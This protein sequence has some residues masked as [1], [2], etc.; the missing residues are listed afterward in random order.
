MHDMHENTI[1]LALARLAH[2]DGRQRKENE[3]W[4]E[5]VAQEFHLFY[6]EFAM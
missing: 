6:Q 4:T 3:K 2:T 5:G 1:Q